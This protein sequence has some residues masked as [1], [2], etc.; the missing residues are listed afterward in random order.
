MLISNSGGK[1]FGCFCTC[2]RRAK[3]HG[4]KYSSRLSK[5]T[6]APGIHLTFSW[7]LITTLFLLAS[8]VEP[9]PGPKRPGVSSSDTDDADH[10]QRIAMFASLE[11]P[12]WNFICFRC[13]KHTHESCL[14]LH[15]N[16]RAEF[17]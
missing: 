5:S 1:K 9:N 14:V 8:G 11:F 17:L 15:L 6:I 16:C 4:Y 13:S 7:L 10:V 2:F 12:T 3:L